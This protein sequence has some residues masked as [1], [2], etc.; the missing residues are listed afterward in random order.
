MNQSQSIFNLH[1]TLLLEMFWLLLMGFLVC[2]SC[3]GY[4]W[5]HFPYLSLPSTCYYCIN[6]SLY[7]GCLHWYILCKLGWNRMMLFLYVSLS[8][9]SL[10]IHLP[11]LLSLS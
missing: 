5:D 3:T 4:F 7:E 8:Y 11:L 10:N 9:L 6:I 1:P 2:S